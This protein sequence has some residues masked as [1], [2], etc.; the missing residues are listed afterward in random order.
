VTVRGGGAARRCGVG[1]FAVACSVVTLWGG[2]WLRV[3]RRGLDVR[4]ALSAHARVGSP[5]PFP[6]S[7]G[8]RGAAARTCS[9]R[10]GVGRRTDPSLHLF[11]LVLRIRFGLRLLLVCRRL[12]PFLHLFASALRTSRRRCRA[13]ACTHPFPFPIVM[14]DVGGGRRWSRTLG[15]GRRRLS[16]APRVP[17]CF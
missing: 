11:D 4:R 5:S 8:G 10:R 2:G 15:A 16:R 3:C 6:G 13:D 14:A 7:A 9:V 1:A 12:T 17:P